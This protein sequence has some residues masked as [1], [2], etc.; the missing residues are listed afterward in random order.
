MSEPTPAEKALERE[1]EKLAARVE[2]H[3]KEAARLKRKLEREAFESLSAVPDNVRPRIRSMAAR[4]ARAG[5]PKLFREW[6]KKSLM[7]QALVQ[8]YR[9]RTSVE[10]E[11]IKRAN[12]GFIKVITPLMGPGPRPKKR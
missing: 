12:E 11:D 3:E 7:L 2:E 6:A 10:I 4:F 8:D 1:A 5:D 9:A